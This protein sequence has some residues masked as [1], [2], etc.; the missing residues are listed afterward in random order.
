MPGIFQVRH[1][2]AF[3]HAYYVLLDIKQS[4]L[5]STATRLDGCTAI[6]L[7]PWHAEFILGNMKINL[8]VLSFLSTEMAHVV[9]ILPYGRPKICSCCIVNIMV[10]DDLET[11]INLTRNI[12]VSA[13]EGLSWNGQKCRHFCS[14][15]FKM[16]FDISIICVRNVL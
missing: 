3:T 8:Y 14:F 16:A 1:S 15:T 4:T 12:P 13:L 9:D 6:G 5:W 2:K 7:N 10:A 11:Q